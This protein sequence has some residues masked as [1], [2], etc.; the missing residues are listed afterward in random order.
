MR[1]K[2]SKLFD[3]VQEPIRHQDHAIMPHLSYA[4]KHLH[5]YQTQVSVILMILLILGTPAALTAN[6]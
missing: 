5:P 4:C 2:L 3:S 1:Q 6:K